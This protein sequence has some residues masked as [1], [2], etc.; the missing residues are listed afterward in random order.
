MPF[1]GEPAKLS[2]L[3]HLSSYAAVT[4][5]VKLVRLCYEHVGILSHA[6]SDSGF[7]VRHYRLV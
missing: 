6:A 5:M 4:I 7:W 3:T 2:G 1:L